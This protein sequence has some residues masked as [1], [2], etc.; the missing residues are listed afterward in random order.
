MKKLR[1]SLNKKKFDSIF[2]VTDRHNKSIK[3]SND[4]CSM[5]FGIYLKKEL[6]GGE[7]YASSQ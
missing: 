5:G 2:E 3:L 1:V 6:N 7:E 4:S